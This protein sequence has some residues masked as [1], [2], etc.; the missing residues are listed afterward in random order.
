MNPLLPAPQCPLTRRFRNREPVSRNTWRRILPFALRFHCKPWSRVG[1][2]KA[3]NAPR[4]LADNRA[5]TTLTWIGHA[6]FLLQIGGLNVLTDPVFS[7]YL[8]ALDILCSPRLAPLGLE[9]AELPKIDLVVVS[10]NHYDHLD[11]RTIER[12]ARDHDP[13]FVVPL[14]LEKWFRRRG[15]VKVRAVNWWE[16]VTL[17]GGAKVTGVPA[18]HYSGRFSWHLDGLPYCSLWCGFV[19]EHAG[20]RVY[21]AG[22]TG[23]CGHF[24]EIGEHFGAIELAMIPIGAYNPQNYMRAVHLDPDEAVQVHLDVR[25]RQSVAMHWGTFRMTLEPLDEPPARLRRALE[26]QGLCQSEFRVLAHGET[27]LV[28]PP[29]APLV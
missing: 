2:P 18:Q 7:E 21:F 5:Q 9:F 11:E 13:E 6:S 16:S 23:Y 28:S 8:T 29:T 27:V 20:Q 12:L 14:G 17:P 1:F 10:H 3:R 25:S 19:L 22:D 15:I 26:N 24:K 4:A